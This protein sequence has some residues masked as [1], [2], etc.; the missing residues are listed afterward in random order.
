MRITILRCLAAIAACSLTQVAVADEDV[1]RLTGAMLGDT[2]VID[3]LHELTD[4]IGGRLTGTDANRKAVAWAAAKLRQAEVNVITE[5]FEMPYKWQERLVRASVAGDVAFNPNVVTKQFSAPATELEGNLLDGGFGSEAD[6]ARLGATAADAWV[7]VETRVLDDDVGLGGLFAEFAEAAAIE[8]RAFAAGVAGVVFMSSRPKNLVYRHNASAGG[9][10]KHP[11]LVM[12]R[13]HAQRALRLLRAGNELSLTATIG[14]ESGS[15]Y[16]ATNVIGEIR[17]NKRPNEIVLFGAHLDSHELGTGAL[18]N[19]VNVAMLINIARQITRLGLTPERTIRFVLWNGEEQGLVGS[20]KYTEQHDG[21]LDNHVVAASFDIGSGR[22]TGFFTGGRGEIIPF[23]DEYLAPVAGLGPFGHAN[24]P[25]VGTDN[26]D[27][28]IQGVPNLVGFQSDANYA[29]NYHAESDTFDK[30]DQ[31]QVRLNSAITAAVIWGFANDTERLP[32]QTHDE[33]QALMD[34]TDLEQQMK[35]LAVW[36]G[37]AN[38]T[39]GRHD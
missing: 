32:R 27:F 8:P 7:L 1:D 2:P 15:S 20:W 12:E 21:E 16:T 11:L 18:D 36:D 23:L 9:V 33:I 14:V 34:G 22:T 38:G 30:V 17:G 3:D 31:Q 24:V 5:D 6:F 25:V 35:N 39:R 19:G 4:A 37:W 29:S 10:N 28:M 26:F 13:E